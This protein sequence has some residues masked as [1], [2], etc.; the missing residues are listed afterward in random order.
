LATRGYQREE[1]LKML[2]ETTGASVRDFLF[3]DSIAFLKKIKALGE[4]M[5]LLSLGNPGFQELKTKGTSVEKYFDR[6]FI[7][8]DTKR[9]VLGE[10]FASLDEESVWFINDKIGE[11]QKLKKA[12][13]QLRPI[14]KTSEIFERSEYHESGFPYFE[15]LTEVEKYIRKNSQRPNT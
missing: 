2:E 11:T 15:S 8:H 1:V 14:L 3:D 10:L 4:P 6:V 13:P 5:V 7:V 12:F 9:H